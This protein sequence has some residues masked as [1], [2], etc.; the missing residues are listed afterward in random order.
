MSN[1]SCDNCFRLVYGK[2]SVSELLPLSK[3]QRRVLVYLSEEGYIHP[4]EIKRKVV[5]NA[6]VNL[7]LKG[8]AEISK[9]GLFCATPL[10]LER[11]AASRITCGDLNL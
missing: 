4:N 11:V 10:G 7:V 8:A 1:G 9:E 6:L 2:P 5:R 3:L